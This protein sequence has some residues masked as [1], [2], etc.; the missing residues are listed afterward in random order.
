MKSL[1]LAAL[2]AAAALG[3][4]ADDF[5]RNLPDPKFAA[6]LTQDR[7]RNHDAVVI[8]KEQALTISRKNF[9][10]RGVD[11]DGMGMTQ[12]VIL[13]AKVF[14][15]RG[16]Q[17]FGSFD[18]EYP[19]RF[20]DKFRSAFACRA[21]VQ[22][23]DGT[24]LVMPES[25]V[26]LIVSEENSDGD[27]IARK[28][29]FKVP[30]LAPGDVVHIE[31]TLAE[32]LV[33]ALSGLFFYNDRSPVLFS[34]L[35]ITLPSDDEIK[36]FSFPANRVGEP[37]SAQVSKTSGPTY[38]WSLR[39][40]NA[41]PDEVDTY[42][43]EDLS[44]MTGFVVNP[45]ING[46]HKL[47]DWN[48]IGREFYE[49]CVDKGSVTQKRI[50]E[51]GFTGDRPAVTM[52]L[53][54]S[55]Y[56]AI[57]HALT[58]KARNSLYPYADDIEQVFRKKT[59]D[60]SDLA[61]I[62]YKILGEWK[63]DVNVVW[64]RDRRRGEYERT[65]P[66][67]NWFNRLGVIVRA[68]SE[69]KVYDFDRSVAAHYALPSFLKAVTAPVVSA[70]GAWHRVLPAAGGCASCIRESHELRFRGM[71]AVRDSEVY[72]C[73][74]TPAEKLRKSV[75]ELQ[76][77]QLAERLR[78]VASSRCLAD[79]DS[80]ANSPVLED[81][82]IVIACTGRAVSAPS[83]VDK[84]VTLKLTNEALRDFRE[85]IFS[86]IRVND[87]VLIDPLAITVCWNIHVP[88]GYDVRTAPADTVIRAVPGLVA[89]L[90]T[91]RGADGFQVRV[92][93]RFTQNVY[94]AD[95]FPRVIGTLDALLAASETS[96]VLAKK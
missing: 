49:H 80:V 16:I 48:T 13:I 83:S 34:N 87:L 94:A 50:A 74:G 23:P 95:L 3:A 69:E 35:M 29:M 70:Q 11:F 19:E 68:G 72:A 42:T 79:A 63:A 85:E 33:R 47:I 51:L 41:I 36:F 31:Y 57:R 24:V 62:F 37:K 67:E 15:E 71:D 5:L 1:V 91:V 27:P 60:A 58:L 44:M 93:A 75:Y 26:Q 65:I 64:I 90:S 20:G 30:D 86:A 7:Y 22:K 8:L 25:D 89:G 40:L 6:T 28:A 21:R 52:K 12:T 46:F 14:T 55:L 53:A 78:K 77:A 84:F 59:G 82:E 17:R 92:E 73:D 9:T 43:F 2:A 38:M 88:A 4:R 10:Y 39:N 66:T 76:G 81:P 32:P 54:D 56:T 61:Y 18:Y 96:I 45:S